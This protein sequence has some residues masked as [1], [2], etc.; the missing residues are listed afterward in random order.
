MHIKS[1]SPFLTCFQVRS[2]F[3]SSLNI[4]LFQQLKAKDGNSMCEIGVAA[5]CSQSCAGT[6]LLQVSLGADGVW[7][8]QVCRG[9]VVGWF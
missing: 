3:F 1:S 5:L 6:W 2:I 7:S 4:P 8:T 9:L